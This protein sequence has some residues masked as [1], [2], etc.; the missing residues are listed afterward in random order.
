[1]PDNQTQRPEEVTMALCAVVN[2]TG[3]TCNVFVQGPNN[4]FRAFSVAANATVLLEA[5][6]GRKALLAFRTS[7]SF[8]V[9]MR[10][11]DVPS[12]GAV[13]PLFRGD[14]ILTPGEG[15][16]R[17]YAADVDAGDQSFNGQSLNALQNSGNTTQAEE[18]EVIGG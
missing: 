2:N 9:V 15:S 14:P 3:V 4:Q 17:Y 18:I 11:I 5:T 12:S 16:A 13:F 8:L 7:N 1:M 10:P 6:T